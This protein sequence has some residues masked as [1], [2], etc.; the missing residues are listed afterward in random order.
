MHVVC[1]KKQ[2]NLNIEWGSRVGM[3]QQLIFKKTQVTVQN[4]KTLKNI[5]E[6]AMVV[7]GLDLNSFDTVAKH[8]IFNVE[9]VLQRSLD[10]IIKIGQTVRL[11][12]AIKAG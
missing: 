2:T 1:P 4:Q 3:K 6:E 7:Q 10:T 9:G 5:L 12:P 8:V 11:I